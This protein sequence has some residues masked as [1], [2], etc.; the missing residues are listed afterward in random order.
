MRK[1]T[2]SLRDSCRRLSYD[3]R[4]IGEFDGSGKLD[5]MIDK[6]FKNGDFKA[7]ED[8]DGVKADLEHHI[9]MRRLYGDSPADAVKNGFEELRRGRSEREPQGSGGIFI[10]SGYMEI[11]GF[12]LPIREG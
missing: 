11:D 12:R 7:G 8:R 4:V 6:G 3:Y 5:E 9:K 2:E 1:D 10:G